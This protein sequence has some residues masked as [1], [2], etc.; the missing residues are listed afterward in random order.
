MES[1]KLWL[2]III[3]FYCALL[4]VLSL[5]Y[6]QVHSFRQD[7]VAGKAEDRYS[8]SVSCCL[9]GGFTAQSTQWGH[10]Q[11]DQFT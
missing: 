8:H 11:S 10:V 9:C 7:R 5:R 3:F 6:R 2:L 1:F 4:V